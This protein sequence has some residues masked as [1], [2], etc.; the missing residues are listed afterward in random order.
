VIGHSEIPMLADMI[1]H[2]DSLDYMYGQFCEDRKL[3]LYTCHTANQAYLKLNQ[4]YSK[5]DVFLLYRFVV[6]ECPHLSCHLVHANW[7][8]ICSVSPC[9]VH[10]ISSHVQVAAELD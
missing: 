5:T 7:S 10:Q 8:T 6:C 2:L 9:D 1:V 4:Y 3:P